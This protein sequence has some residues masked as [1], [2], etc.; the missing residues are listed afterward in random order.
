[1]TALKTTHLCERAHTH[2]HTVKNFN[3]FLSHCK[4]LLNID[5]G[6]RP[7]VKKRNTWPGWSESQRTPF[8]PEK[9]VKI[10]SQ[11]WFKKNLELT[12]PRHT[13]QRAKQC[14]AWN[15]NLD[16]RKFL[17]KPFIEKPW[18]NCFSEFGIIRI[19]K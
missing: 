18:A 15:G 1:M 12:S 19:W 14:W 16:V 4:C 2:T 3:T 17:K 8:V 10:K 13:S 7:E 6:H 11:I 9:N 5:C